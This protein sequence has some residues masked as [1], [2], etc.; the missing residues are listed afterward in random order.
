M[1]PPLPSIPLTT[2][3]KWAFLLFGL[4]NNFPYVVFLSAAVSLVEESGGKHI[5]GAVNYQYIPTRGEYI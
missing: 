3:Q 1:P 5:T 2:V 4:C